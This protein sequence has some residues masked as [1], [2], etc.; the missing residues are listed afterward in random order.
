[1]TLNCGGREVKQGFAVINKIASLIEKYS[2]RCFFIVNSGSQAFQFI[3]RLQPIENIFISAI[4]CQPF[5]AE[6][7]QEAILLRHKSS[8]FKFEIEKIHED[9]FS[10]LRLAKLFNSY[11]DI[12]RGNI[13]LA[14]LIWI[15][16]IQKVKQN[17]IVINKPD[18][19]KDYFLNS[20]NPDWF[21]LLQQFVLHKQLHLNR[22]TRI[23]GLDG[24]QNITFN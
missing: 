11:F 24:I 5:D 6:E 14:I 17:Q 8:G 15:S 4:H 9:Q 16:S 23:L 19:V 2:D 13:G 7:I 18:E 1:M 21:L 3:N 10:N 20:I 12:S 22:I